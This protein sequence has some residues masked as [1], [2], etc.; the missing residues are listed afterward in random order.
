ML[1]LSLWGVI[2]ASFKM[3]SA[4]ERMSIFE[5]ARMADYAMRL[6][7]AATDGNAQEGILPAGQVIGGI[8]DILSCREIIEQIVADAERIMQ[9]T[10]HNVCS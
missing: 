4:E 5:Q 2:R 6:P 9:S 7:Q 10:T 1:N 8:H 3:A